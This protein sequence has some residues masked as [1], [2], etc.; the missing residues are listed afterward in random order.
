[1]ETSNVK[2]IVYNDSCDI[3]KKNMKQ[4]FKTQSFCL[5]KASHKEIERF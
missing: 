4:K 1:M 5:A 2:S 3:G